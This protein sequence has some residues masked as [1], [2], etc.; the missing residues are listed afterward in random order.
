VGDKKFYKLK[1]PKNTDK[2]LIV[3]IEAKLGRYGS[4]ECL[5]LLVKDASH[6]LQIEKLQS[7]W[8]QSQMLVSTLSH[9]Q[10]DPLN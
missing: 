6:L 5:L 2:K 1:D 7:E 9:K 4:E 3:E 8:D 10:L